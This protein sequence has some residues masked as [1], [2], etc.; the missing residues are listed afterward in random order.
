MIRAIIDTNV[1]MSGIF[2]S[3]MPAKILDAWQEKKIK[4]VIS[5]DILEEYTRV[6]K[7]LS[8]KYSGV[9]IM[10]IIDLIT[11]YSELFTP[12]PLPTSVSR[13]PDDDKFLALAIAA[14]CKIIITGDR[15]LLD[16]QNY[17]GVTCIKP[18]DF[19]KLYLEKK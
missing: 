9:D 11:I 1:L 5:P 13:D 6:S 14:N 4:V 17:A 10:P 15:D 2:W 18:I 8:K 16:I 3:G 7:I 19:I 12:Q